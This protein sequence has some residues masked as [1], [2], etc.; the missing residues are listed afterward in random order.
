MAANCTVRFFTAVSCWSASM[1]PE[2][3]FGLILNRTTRKQSGRGAGGQL[4]ENGQGSAPV[5]WRPCSTA[6]PEL[7]AQR[8]LSARRQRDAEL[9]RGPFAGRVDGFE[10]VLFRPQKLKL[11]A[12][13]AGWSAGQLDKEMSRQDW[14]VHPASHRIDFS[15]RAGPVWQDNPAAKRDK[16][17]LLADS[18]D[19]LS[20]N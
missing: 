3:A 12:G 15:R 5:H 20:W 18:P 10:R 13:Y 16:S 8:R 4:P 6:N 7:S 9:K 19:D 11:F 1:T 17:R 14:L 2:G